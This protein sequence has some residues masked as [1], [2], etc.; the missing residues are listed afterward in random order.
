[1]TPPQADRLERCIL[2]TAIG[3]VL[4]MSIVIFMALLLSGCSA[5]Q[6]HVAAVG[7]VSAE[8]FAGLVQDEADASICGKPTAPPAPVC[9][10]LDQRKAIAPYL[11]EAFTL[12]IQG[13]ETVKTL[14][15]NATVWTVVAANAER[16]KTLLQQA[17]NLLPK[18]G[19][20]QVTARVAAGGN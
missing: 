19:Q 17:F 4:A 12:I 16:I 11:K 13:G 2:D 9:L 8:T 18:S 10:T 6:Y 3:Y 20:T 1:M 5:K 14:G 7:V 15:P